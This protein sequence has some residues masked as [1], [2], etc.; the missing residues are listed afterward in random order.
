MILFII[1]L[2]FTGETL[3]FLY[4]KFS[5]LFNIFIKF[6]QFYFYFN[7]I[8]NLIF[9]PLNCFSRLQQVRGLQTGPLPGP[10]EGVRDVQPAATPMPSGHQSVRFWRSLVCN[11]LKNAK[12]NKTINNSICKKKHKP[13]H[14]TLIKEKVKNIYILNTT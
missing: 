7:L 8:F 1:F 4:F 14:P 3:F 2:Q 6:C 11:L 5:Q 10:V 9:T 12:K 13:E